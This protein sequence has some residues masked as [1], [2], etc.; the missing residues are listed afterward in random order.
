M[1]RLAK[2]GSPSRGCREE[3]KGK[4]TPRIAPAVAVAVTAALTGLDS[5]WHL[6]VGQQQMGSV[7]IGKTASASKEDGIREGRAQSGNPAPEE[8]ALGEAEVSPLPGNFCIRPVQGR[9]G[10]KDQ[11]LCYEALLGLRAI[12]LKHWK[13]HGQ[14]WTFSFPQ[15]IPTTTP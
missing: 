1:L 3:N 5:R 15:F 8:R 11:R 6:G 9:P 7:K 13:V 4:A 12:K 2:A 10:S 14:S